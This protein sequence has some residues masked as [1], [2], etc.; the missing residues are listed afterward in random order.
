MGAIAVWSSARQ[1]PG[2]EVEVRVVQVEARVAGGDGSP[3]R[4]LGAED[5]VVLEDGAPQDISSVRYIARP[6]S[7]FAEVDS[8]GRTDATPGEPAFEPV[9]IYLAIELARA[10]DFVRLAPAI[11]S[12]IVEQLQPGVR[13]SLAG[14][15]FSDNERLLL[16]ALE[17]MRRGPYGGGGREGVVDPQ[18][19]ELEDLEFE[20][21]MAQEMRRMEGGIAPLSGF[22]WDPQWQG[23]LDEI[24]TISLERLDR[25][26]PL[27]GRLALLRYK[28]L[29]ERISGLSG[30]KAIVLFRPGLGLDRE[31]AELFY[32]VVSLA[33]RHRV[34]FYASDPKGLDADVV[35]EN[36]RTSMAWD[37]GRRR[38]P[39][40]I[41]SES[42]RR[43]E[44]QGGLASIAKETGGQAV[45]DT[46]DMG[47]I[48][49]KA[50]A[51]AYDYYLIEYTPISRESK[52]RFRKIDVSVKRPGVKISATRGYYEPQRLDQD[53]PTDGDPAPFEV[54]FSSAPNHFPVSGSVKVFADRDGLP[55]LVCSAG[56]RPRELSAAERGSDVE[57]DLRAM[58]RLIDHETLQLPE[59]EE[60][61]IRHSVPSYRWRQ[62]LEDHSVFVTHNVQIPVFPGR[63]SWKIVF[64]DR[65]SGKFGSFEAHIQIPDF[66]QSS[67]PSSLLLTSEV[68]PLSEIVSD[69]ADDGHDGPII[70]V[71]TAGDLGYS[72]QLTPVFRRGEIIYVLYH[73]YNPT[74]DDVNAISRGL[75]IGLMRAG[76]PV[77]D[78]R[79]GGQPFQDSDGR[80]LR[81]AAWVDS[82]SLEPGGYTFVAILPNAEGRPVPH[83][84]GN[85]TLLP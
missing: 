31:T 30:K 53:V 77:T 80:V 44:S 76:G 64:E 37:A 61:S 12:F 58:T 3:V 83:L 39:P 74:A 27:F 14:L 24:S 47:E 10:N 49:K 34:S 32:Q 1:A 23:R 42:L 63:Y 40:N 4:G 15:P 25:Q 62:A 79:A 48:L 57:V 8:D 67:M 51:D 29:I 28:G 43:L 84:E 71:L 65:K 16:G 9:W 70:T 66:Q 33:Q 68:T 38:T 35:E 82:A 2:H 69:G 75:E 20:R 26:I 36:R 78:V 81:V 45:T 13:I 6:D 19:L 17:R 22:G 41:T 21:M 50:L 11:R 85:F 59:F 60:R 54:L 72:P 73:L 18:L 55:V 46:N 52:G 56:I 7:V 5:F